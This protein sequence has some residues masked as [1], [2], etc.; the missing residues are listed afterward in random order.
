MKKDQ[1]KITISR[2][3]KDQTAECTPVTV[4]LVCMKHAYGDLL[5]IYCINIEIIQ[6]LSRTQP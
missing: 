3:K 5:G 2:K 4:N 1:K 6:N